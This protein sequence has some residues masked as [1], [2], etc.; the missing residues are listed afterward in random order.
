MY[1]K[2]KQKEERDGIVRMNNEW[3]NVFGQETGGGNDYCCLHS[4]GFTLVLFPAAPPRPP[5]RWPRRVPGRLPPSD[6]ES[7]QPMS[8]I[9]ERGDLP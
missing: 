4:S 2:K 8:L 9:K 3:A 6:S 1:M 5:R 7:Y